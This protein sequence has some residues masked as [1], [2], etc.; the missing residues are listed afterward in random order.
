VLEQVDEGVLTTTTG[1]VQCLV[2]CVRRRYY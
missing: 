2:T 1:W